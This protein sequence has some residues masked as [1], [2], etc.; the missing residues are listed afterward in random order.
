MLCER[1][2]YSLT[3][4]HYY[5]VHGGPSTA[6]PAFYTSLQ[7]LDCIVLQP[8]VRQRL[9][10]ETHLAGAELAEI[11][12]RL[13]KLCTITPALT[14]RHISDQDGLGP[15]EILVK[16]SVLVTLDSFDD[17]VGADKTFLHEL[18]F[19]HYWREISEN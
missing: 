11:Q 19:P 5:P 3:F 12:E 6:D 2:E 8:N 16:Q 1:A 7:D 15:T 10:P 14:T 4:D 13:T 17:A 18:T 9:D